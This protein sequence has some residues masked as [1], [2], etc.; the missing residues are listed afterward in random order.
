LEGGYN[1]T[2]IAYSMTL[3]TKA[4]LGDPI[5]PLT[6]NPQVDPS[7]R[8][9]I[10]NVLNTHAKYWKTLNQFQKTLPKDDGIVLPAKYD[11]EEDL[12]TK[13]LKNLG[14]SPGQGPNSA[15]DNTNAN[16]NTDPIIPDPPP[17]SGEPSSSFP[18]P[19]PPPTAI[20][21]R[22]A[23]QVQA[24]ISQASIGGGENTPVV[25]EPEQPN[26][27]EEALE[28]AVGGMTVLFPQSLQDA[29]TAMIAESATPRD[30]RT[31]LV[32][33]LSWCPH[34]EIVNP[35]PQG[36]L[37][38]REACQEC[39]GTVENWIC[40]TCYS[41][42]C[43]RYVQQ[44]M[45]RHS[46]E[47]GHPIALSFAD[48]SVWCYGCDSYLDSDSE[49]IRPAKRAAHL[50]KFGVDLPGPASTNSTSSHS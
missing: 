2:S 17:A 12:L 13:Q 45:V 10:S 27:D 6:L 31:Y 33:P 43:G 41:V 11:R 35:V 23:V 40:L 3:C 36:G 19:L 18:S 39:Q 50:S 7:A 8:N 14:L 44:H 47:T 38:W 4:L 32:A 15:E 34:M 9:S 48:L 46:D 16:A 21:R 28:G 42:F 24:Q 26:E 25:P 20:I 29:Q 22:P 49:T 5:P 1:L 30:I 37:N